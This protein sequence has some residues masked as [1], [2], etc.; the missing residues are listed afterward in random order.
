MEAWGG[1]GH[2]DLWPVAMHLLAQS[3]DISDLIFLICKMGD[4]PDELSSKIY[5]QPLGFWHHSPGW[6][7]HKSLFLVPFLS[8]FMLLSR[9][10]FSFPLNCGQSI[11]SPKFL[12]QAGPQLLFLQRGN[13][14]RLGQKGTES[15]SYLT[16][17]V[18]TQICGLEKGW[19][20]SD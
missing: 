12:S 20:H 17:M 9:T 2:E 19:K 1:G 3:L 5:K 16:W 14:V 18:L 6:R 7:N 11:P 8:P 15:S 4:N 10:H 13:R